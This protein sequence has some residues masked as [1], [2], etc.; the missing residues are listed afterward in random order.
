MIASPHQQP[1]T[2]DQYLQLE[3]ES[4]V[5]HDYIDGYIYAQAGA[6]DAHNTIAGNLFALLRN[7]V[8][9]SGCRVYISDMKVR[10]ESRNRFYY[11]DILVTCDP[12]DQETDTFKRFPRLIVEVLS[13][14]TEAFDRGD[15]FVDYQAIETLQEY[16]L[17]NTKHQ[18]VDCFRR[19]AEGLWVFQYYTA[20]QHAF[21]L[22]SID[23]E[24]AIDFLYEDVTLE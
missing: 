13:D 24:V 18:R 7:H 9:G 22:H 5:K 11:P 16:I 19:N 8:R 6:T 3:A 1:L 2:P 10:I 12:R 20:A 21:Q 23:F 14:S 15:K 4:P 17:I